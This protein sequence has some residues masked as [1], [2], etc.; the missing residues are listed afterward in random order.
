LRPSDPVVSRGSADGA[1]F[2]SRGGTFRGICVAVPDPTAIHIIY[3]EREI[4]KSR[5]LTEVQDICVRYMCEI[6]RCGY[7]TLGSE[8][9]VC[10]AVLQLDGIAVWLCFYCGFGCFFLG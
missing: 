6:Y 2:L 5:R 4:D 7:V 10:W 8:G 9:F 1:A 3:I